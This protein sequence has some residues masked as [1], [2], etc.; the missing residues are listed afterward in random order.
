MSAGFAAGRPYH[1][2]LTSQEILDRKL[3]L[4]QSRLDREK[5]E[6]RRERRDAAE[7]YVPLAAKLAGYVFMAVVLWYV[8]DAL[9]GSPVEQLLPDGEPDVQM[10]T[11]GDT[12]TAWVK[13]EDLGWYVERGVPAGGEVI[14]VAPADVLAGHFIV[15]SRK[16][17]AP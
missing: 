12:A 5:R 15:V 13:R 14:S 3:A 4:E 10:R 2:P 9:L 6:R 1:A 11:N 7:A 8:L 16:P 17:E